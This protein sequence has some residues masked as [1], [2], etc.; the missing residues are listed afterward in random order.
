MF[1]RQSIYML[2]VHQSTWIPLIFIFFLGGGGLILI[3]LYFFF[4]DISKILPTPLSEED[5]PPH[6][7]YE[8]SPK[9]TTWYFVVPSHSLEI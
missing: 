9:W 2:I 5:T 3:F 6:T 4:L 1:V 8:P 7:T